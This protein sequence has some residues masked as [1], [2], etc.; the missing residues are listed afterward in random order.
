MI[1]VVTVD[2]TDVVVN[3][4][5]L[6]FFC[7][8]A[9]HHKRTKPSATNVR[10]KSKYFKINNYQ[11]YPWMMRKL[12]ACIAEL[13]CFFSTNKALHLGGEWWPSG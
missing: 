6:P 3:L 8:E 5:V 2:N 13:T 9:V 1:S 10:M 12:I 4:I 11:H 7:R